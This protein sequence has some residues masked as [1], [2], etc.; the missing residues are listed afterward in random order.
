MGKPKSC[1][2]PEGGT[3]GPDP[4]ILKNHKIIGFLSN[5]G[6]DPLKITKLSNQASIQCLAIIGTPA[7]GR[8]NGVS[9]GANDG[10]L[11]VIF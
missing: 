7:K 11:I 4:S 6:P 5:T 2:N 10:P 9:W 1:T 8:L 3:G